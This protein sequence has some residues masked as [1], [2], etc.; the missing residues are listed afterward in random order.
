MLLGESDSDYKKE[1]YI[2]SQEYLTIINKYFIKHN[3]TNE[4]I[5]SELKSSIEYLKLKD[6]YKEELQKKGYAF[7]E[8]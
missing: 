1:I 2:K 8:S 4:N 6:F 7:D 3:C 5:L